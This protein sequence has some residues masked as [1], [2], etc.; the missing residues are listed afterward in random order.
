MGFRWP[1]M[2]GSGGAQVAQ[3]VGAIGAGIGRLGEVFE[4]KQARVRLDDFKLSVTKRMIE[5]GNEIGEEQD[6]DKYQAM[7][8]AAFSDLQG[9]IPKGMAGPLATS[10]LNSEKIAQLKSVDVSMELRVESRWAAQNLVHQQ[11]AI[12]S[13]NPIPF[14][15]SVDVGLVNGYIDEEEAEKLRQ[16]VGAKINEA[17]RIKDIQS[18]IAVARTKDNLDDALDEILKVGLEAG[19]DKADINFAQQQIKDD[20]ARFEAIQVEGETNRVAEADAD[21]S[22]R[23]YDPQNMTTTEE[24]HD[25]NLPRTVRDP[26]L[27]SIRQRDKDIAE[28]KKIV[29]SSR[30]RSDIN[31]RI[32]FV[33]SGENTV[34]QAVNQY[35]RDVQQDVAVDERGADINALFK[36][37]EDNKDA[38]KRQNQTIL[39]ERGNKLRDAVERST[40]II[41]LIKDEEREFLIDLANDAVIELND[42]FRDLDFTV[43]EID[44]FNDTLM[45]TYVLSQQAVSRAVR[46]KTVLGKDTFKKQV[47]AQV[48]LIQSLASNP[49]EQGLALDEGMRLGLVNED[50]TPSTE[51]REPITDNNQFLDALFNKR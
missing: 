44:A 50:G 30:T 14:L 23:M 16:R 12:E 45:T 37:G 42:R 48:A 39:T 31:T 36:A 4:E 8:D 19:I 41:Q 43:T 15:D 2:P 46:M 28:K 5:L 24:V 25:A 18:L 38:K 21:L 34:E 51:A 26:L 47:A 13:T 29:T 1:T 20:F 32:G 7:M 6:E 11:E 33:V 40:G 22:R 10:Y 3:Q 49:I 35:I 9:Q 27:A 17:R